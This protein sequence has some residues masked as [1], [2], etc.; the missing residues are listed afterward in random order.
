MLPIGFVTLVIIGRLFFFVYREPIPE[1]HRYHL[2]SRIAQPHRDDEV[3]ITL[4]DESHSGGKLLLRVVGEP[5][6]TLRF[7]EGKLIITGE[8]GEQ[9]LFMPLPQPLQA[10][11]YEIVLAPDEYWLLAPTP[12]MPEMIDSRHLGSI[13][14]SQITATVIW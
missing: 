1:G 11:A 3:L 6:D 4:P 12:L 8:H 13:H 14:R 10:S 7:L 9:T 2:M 5:S